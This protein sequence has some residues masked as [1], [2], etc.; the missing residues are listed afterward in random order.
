MVAI[1]GSNLEKPM[2]SAWDVIKLF[3]QLG[4]LVWGASTLR[5]EVTALSVDVKKL[6]S[7]ADNLNASVN[8]LIRQGDS[9]E[10]RLKALEKG[11]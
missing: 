9:F 7:S 10:F 5:S 11:Q 1:G 8:S 2:F 6:S 3:L 4:A